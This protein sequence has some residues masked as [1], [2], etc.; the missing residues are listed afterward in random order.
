MTITKDLLKQSS[1]INVCEFINI[2]HS[3][4]LF[5]LI[6]KQTR[7]TNTTATLIDQIWSTQAEMNTYNYIIHSDTTDHFPVPSQFNMKNMTNIVPE[8]M[9]K[10]YFTEAAC[11]KFS[12]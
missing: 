5:P 8:L 2:M 3:F 12:N 9:F 6:T 4:S 7:I 10:S 1:N 11:E